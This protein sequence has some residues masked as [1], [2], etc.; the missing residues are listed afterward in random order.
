MSIL[1]YLEIRGDLVKA[2]GGAAKPRRVSFE[3]GVVIAL[4]GPEGDLAC[5]IP[6][7]SHS[8]PLPNLLV[9]K[10]NYVLRSGNGIGNV[11]NLTTV[12]P[13]LGV[14]IHISCPFLQIQSHGVD[15][16]TIVAKD[17]AFVVFCVCLRVVIS[18]EDT[19]ESWNTE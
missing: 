11:V 7:A 12:A 10:W 16:A 15:G 14:A 17:G 18:L 8:D 5:F 2:R 13:D 9:S 6:K 3:I 19:Q 1:H 4:H